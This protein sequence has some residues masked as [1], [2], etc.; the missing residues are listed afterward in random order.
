MWN[1]RRE[2]QPCTHFSS[3][4]L[5]A[6]NIE[7]LTLSVY[8]NVGFSLVIHHVIPN[9]KKLK[10]VRYVSTPQRRRNISRGFSGMG[11]ISFGCISRQGGCW[12]R[13][14]ARMGRWW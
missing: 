1:C 2:I 4:I 7:D 6:S 8:S 3:T 12:I 5:K 13:C 9:M 10:R 11:L 14:W